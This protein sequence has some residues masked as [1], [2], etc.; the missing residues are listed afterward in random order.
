M[1]LIWVPL[2]AYISYSLYQLAFFESLSSIA[3]DSVN[4]FVMARHY[5]PWFDESEAIRQVWPLQDFPPLFPLLLAITGASHSLLWAH[6][7]V[8]V[9]GLTSLYPFYR[10][11]SGILSSKMGAHLSVFILA[12]TPGYLLGLQGILSES[13]YLFLSLILIAQFIKQGNKTNKHLVLMGLLLAGCMLTRTVGFVLLFS[14][15]LTGLIIAFRHKKVPIALLKTGGVAMLIYYV[16]VSVIGPEN[17]SHYFSVLEG[18]LSGK[19]PTGIGV[20]WGVVAAQFETI[21]NAWRTFFLIYWLNDYGVTSVLIMVFAL[22]SLIGMSVRIRENQVDAW[23]TAGYLLLLLLWPHP[24]QMVR[25]MLPIVP[26]LLI[27]VGSAILLLSRR[28][29]RQK[30]ALVFSYIILFASVIPVHAFLHGRI[31]VAKSY[32]MI[33]VYE[34]FRRPNLISAKRELFIQNQM[35]IDYSTLGEHVGVGDKVIYSVPEYPAVLGDVA[36]ALS[37]FPVFRGEYARL[38]RDEGSNMILMTAMHPRNTRK[39]FDGFD[40]MGNLQGVAHPVWCSYEGQSGEKVSC[41]Y[42]F[43]DM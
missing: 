34:I 4:Y 10:V 2:L 23:Y 25:L 38:A 24:G 12:I 27:Y 31:A 35:L 5:S 9:I 41:L 43:T 13:L 15:L 17:D 8:V 29:S 42:Q 40:S 33:P 19:D 22:L 3:N 36:T 30:M 28:I 16:V 21:M 39:G 14:M 11:A 7:L 1:Y 18:F 32:N 20:G 37:S 6:V 26:L